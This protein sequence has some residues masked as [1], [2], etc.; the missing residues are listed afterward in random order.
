M[1]AAALALVAVVLLWHAW[2]DYQWS[3]ERARLVAAA[4]TAAANPFDARRALIPQPVEH[5][6]AGKDRPTTVVAVGDDA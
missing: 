4:I 2:R 3:K 5:H 1:T 6:R